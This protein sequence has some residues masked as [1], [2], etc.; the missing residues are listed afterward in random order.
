MATTT[1]IS[2]SGTSQR[3]TIRVVGIDP[4]LIVTGYAVVESSL[5]WSVR[6]RG[7]E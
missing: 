5:A 2:T 4:G 7:R 6:R 1:G 3:P